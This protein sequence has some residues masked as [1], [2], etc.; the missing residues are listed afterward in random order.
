MPAFGY[1]SARICASGLYAGVR[2]ATCMPGS[3]ARKLLT[4]RWKLVA[5]MG[6]LVMMQVCDQPHPLLVAK[7]VKDCSKSRLDEAYKGMK[8]R[9][10]HCLQHLMTLLLKSYPSIGQSNSK[11][12]VH[13][14]DDEGLVH[15]VDLL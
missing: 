12:F 3:R 10:A 6:A 7:I 5:L 4:G 11:K 1:I 13:G 2:I 8:V 14:Q 15:K 9:T